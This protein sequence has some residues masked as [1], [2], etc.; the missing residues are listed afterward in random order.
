MAAH[1]THRPVNRYREANPPRSATHEANPMA[2]EKSL[3]D[4]RITRK[5]DA[6]PEISQTTLKMV[7]PR[8]ICLSKSATLHPLSHALQIFTEASRKDWGAD[9]GDLTAG[10]MWSLP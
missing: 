2:S 7:A 9:L 3:E 4:L 1:V 8:G 6:Y 10:G 5:G